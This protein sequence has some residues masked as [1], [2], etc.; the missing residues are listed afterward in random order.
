MTKVHFI[1]IGGSGLSAIARL[2]LE[3]GYTVSGSDKTLS[4]LARDLAD[5]GVQVKIGHNPQNVEGA[6]LVIRSSAVPDDNPEV[7]SALAAGIPVYKRADFLGKLMSGRTGIAVAGTHGKTT[8]TTMIAWM[9]SSLGQDPSYIIGGVSKNL[10]ANAHA[11]NGRPFVIEADEYDRMFLGLQPKIIVVTNVEHDHPD[12]YPT[13]ADYLAAFSE[14]VSSLEPEG[15][16]LVC[17]DDPGALSLMGY[18]PGDCTAC[19]YGLQSGN[20][21]ASA[22][23]T[24]SRGGF[25]FEFSQQVSGSPATLLGTVSLQIPGKHNVLNA[26]AALAVAH[27]LG[28]PVDQAASALGAYLGSGRRFDILGESHGIVVVDDYAHHPTEIRAT[29]SAARTRYPGRRLWAVWQ[30]HT[31][32]RTQSLQEDF[33]QSFS[34]ADQVLVTEVYAAREKKQDFSA[35]QLVQKMH[36][37]NINFVPTLSSAVERLLDQLRSGDV[38]LVLSAGDADQISTG[39]LSGLN[40]R[41]G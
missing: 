31:Y 3:S 19:T 11:G 37:A 24:N 15:L 14:F 7:L 28:L 10:H 23:K 4:P 26:T 36:A 5:S 13:P 40:E 35:E 9:L 17:Q 27:Q 25:D 38:L 6:D 29:L 12:C 22:I 1:G 16:L 39:V 20:Y 34:D 18:V 2:L 32:S 8:T 41:E 30:P 33:C 21:Q